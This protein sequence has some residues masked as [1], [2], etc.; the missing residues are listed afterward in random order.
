IMKNEIKKGG[1][2]DFWEYKDGIHNGSF[3][4][5]TP[6]VIHEDYDGETLYLV[7]KYLHDNWK[8]YGGV[9]LVSAIIEA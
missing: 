7:P 8:H 1:Y 4:R 6:L 5:N 2:Y 9:A 3:V